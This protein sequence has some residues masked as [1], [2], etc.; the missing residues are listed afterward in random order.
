MTTTTTFQKNC[1]CRCATASGP[2][3]SIR[4]DG[5]P[6]WVEN[7]GYYWLPLKYE[8]ADMVCDDCDTPWVASA[9][10]EGA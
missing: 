8:W 4:G 6:V 7:G 9:P 2:R 1:D 10:G 5:P 3:L